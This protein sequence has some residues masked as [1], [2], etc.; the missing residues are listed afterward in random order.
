MNTKKSRLAFVLR[1]AACVFFLCALTGAAWAKTLSLSAPSIANEGG[2]LVVRFGVVVEDLPILKG[3]LD[4]GLTLRLSCEAALSRDFD[5][6]MDSHI[7][8]ATFE[9]QISRDA[10]AGEYVME[11]PGLERP[12]RNVDLRELL[13]QG[14]SDIAVKL[15]PWETLTRGHT[16]NLRLTNLIED[17]EA[18]E[19]LT[20]YLYFWSWD[21]GS[22]SS[23][24][25]KFTY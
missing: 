19:G 24:Q 6:W 20:R 10:L 5:Y 16:Y 14:W 21:A 8:S 17:A 12:L 25:L 23:F 15:G 18:P 4:D 3:E 11:L 13:R 7:T 2:D 22:D 1:A 9:S